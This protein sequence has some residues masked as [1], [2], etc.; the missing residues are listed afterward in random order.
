[1]FWRQG[2]YTPIRVPISALF[3]RERKGEGRGEEGRRGR[4]GGREEEG[5]EGGRGKGGG[6]EGR[7]EEGR[8][9]GREKNGKNREV[10]GGKLKV[11]RQ[12]Q[13]THATE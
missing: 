1:M 4:E 7:E 3:C 9:G 10:E 11:Q 6:E 8:E 12:Q 5:R 2:R 13:A